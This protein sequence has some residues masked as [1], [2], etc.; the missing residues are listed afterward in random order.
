MPP[1]F[2]D[3]RISPDSIT[4]NLDFKSRKQDIVNQGISKILITFLS[5]GD[6]ADITSTRSKSRR[7]ASSEGKGRNGNNIIFS[8][9]S[10][11]LQLYP[12]R[13]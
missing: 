8:F 1:S 6:T 3:P 11:S 2:R 7:L 10:F 4:D 5:T 12:I 13:I 9:E